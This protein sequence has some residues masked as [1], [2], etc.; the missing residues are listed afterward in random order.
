MW[1][2]LWTA[3]STVL[4]VLLSNVFTALLKGDPPPRPSPM[5]ESGEIEWPEE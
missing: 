3:I 5:E 1:K 2:V 4:V